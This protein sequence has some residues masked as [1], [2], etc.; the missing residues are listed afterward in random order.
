MNKSAFLII[1]L[2]LLATAFAY[3]KSPELAMR[4]GRSAFKLFIDVLPALIAG[5]VLGGMVQVLVP[6]EIIARWAGADSGWSGLALATVAGALTPGGPFVQFPLVA[7][8]WKAGAT[9]GPLTAYL[10]AWTLLGINKTFVWEVPILGW[11][12]TVAKTVACMAAPIVLGWLAALF[13]RH[14]DGL[15]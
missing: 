14:L 9:V 3:Y 12:Y 7:S 4:G 6:K 5:F 2:A 1:G 11:R 10:I 15:S 8:L 13:Y